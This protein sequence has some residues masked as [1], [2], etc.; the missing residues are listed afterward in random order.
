MRVQVCEDQQHLLQSASGQS[1]VQR[2]PHRFLPIEQVDTPPPG[3]NRFSQVDT[4]Q[5]P[6]PLG[7]SLPVLSIFLPYQQTQVPKHL[8]R[9]SLAEQDI[10]PPPLQYRL[11]GLQPRH[12]TEQFDLERSRCRNCLGTRQR[13]GIGRAVHQVI[14]LIAEGHRDRLDAAVVQHT[15]LDLHANVPVAGPHGGVVPEVARTPH[16]HRDDVEPVERRRG[17]LLGRRLP[18]LLLPR[19]DRLGPEGQRLYGG[20]LAAVVGPDEHRRVVELDALRVAER[21][22]FR[23]SR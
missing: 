5:A 14:A 15:D 9:L 7:N 2:L 4:E 21:L 12:G 20:R 23:I 11:F 1:D 6:H 8:C 3:L 10:D 22:K 16:R 17:T 13:L 19:P 18:L